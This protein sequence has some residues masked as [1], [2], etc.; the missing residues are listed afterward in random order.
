MAPKPDVSEVRKN[1]I[2]QAAINVFTRQGFHGARMDDIV[3][4]SGLSKGTL[5]WYYK[6]KEELIISI[7]D[8][9]FAG[10]FAKME[11]LKN[12]N[13]SARQGLHK[14][15]EA[16]IAELQKMLIFAPII[17][18]FYALAFR[19]KTVRVVMQRYLHTFISIV[20]PI[21]QYG[22]D[23][24]ELR[25]VDAHQ[26]AIA[27]GAQLEGTLLLWA[28]APDILSLEDQLRSGVKLLFDSIIISEDFEIFENGGEN[29]SL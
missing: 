19:N 11:A 6:S 28:Y 24:G 1:Q 25:D 15:L 8:H 13:I 27:L 23:N 2:I 18:E 16:Y 10:E 7:L 17:Y 29:A 3:E 9:I 22:I 14:F 26:A 5:Y 4:E 12:E 20:E 21:I